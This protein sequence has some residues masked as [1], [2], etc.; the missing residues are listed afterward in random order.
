L[1]VFPA[2]ESEVTSPER[3]GFIVVLGV[4][5]LLFLVAESPGFAQQPAYVLAARLLMSALL[6]AAPVLLRRP[7]A[8]RSVQWVVYTL[9]AGV[10]LA[11]AAIAWGTGGTLSPYF[12]F[13]PMLPLVFTIAV[14][15]VPLGSLLAGACAGGVGLARVWSEGTRAPEA[16]F[17]VL[18]F[19]STTTYAVAGSIFNRR[20]RARERR[21]VEERARAEEILAESERQRARAE[22]LALAGRLAAGVAHDVANP[23]SVVMASVGV[24]EQH[25]ASGSGDD[26]DLA[27]TFADVRV[28]LDRIQRTVEDLRRVAQTDVGA[29]EDCDLAVV[30]EEARLTLQERF[31]ASVSIVRV[32]PAELPWVHA[33]RSR[34]VH[35]LVWI[36]VDA[37][38]RG[39]RRLRVAACRDGA[40]VIV[41]LEDDRAD[42]SVA[43]LDLPAAT[44]REAG[45][46]LALAR[47][48]L[49][50]A[51]CH[52]EGAAPDGD[53]R[54]PLR[55]RCAGCGD[56]AAHGP[57]RR[58]QGA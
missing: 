20:Q 21:L 33:V 37:S 39:V 35:A 6:L 12:A 13:L 5:S 3:R 57:H 27:Y 15:D 51:G 10:C 47:E 58:A 4:M 26:P 1:R 54:M 31:R 18:A 48:D 11:F 2:G 17:W 25:V 53:L 14:P 49:L 16:L 8:P 24:I 40:E 23:L 52:A 43:P 36:L 28:S 9:C 55:I 22:R 7:L 41:D 44:V 34:L 30:V 38:G 19:T 50:R 45:L 42:L 56:A 46:A 32:P 29:S